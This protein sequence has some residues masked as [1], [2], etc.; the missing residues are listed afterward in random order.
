[1]HSDLLNS[2]KEIAD[3]LGRGVRTA[4]RWEVEL[5]LPVRR[6]HL[7]PRSS[8]TALKSDLDQWVRKSGQSAKG[9]KVTLADVRKTT[10]I[11]KVHRQEMRTL[12]TQVRYQMQQTLGLL[13]RACELASKH[14]VSKHKQSHR[15]SAGQSVSNT[16]PMILPS[17]RSVPFRIH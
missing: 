2:W 1:V 13:E 12:T 10:S 15:H 3:Y 14:E 7:R 11:L 17:G 9:A 16:H 8:V 4:Q 6:P 5:H